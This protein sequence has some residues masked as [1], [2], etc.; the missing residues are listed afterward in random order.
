MTTSFVRRS[1]QLVTVAAA[2][3]TLAACEDKRVKA[4]DTGMTR[5]QALTQLAQEAKGSGPDSMPN[6]YTKSMYLIDGKQYEVLYFT[7]HNEKAKRDTV[8]WDDLTPIVLLDNR[9]IGKGWDFWDSAGKAMKIAV[10][11]HD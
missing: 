1:T 8:E 5:D 7:K 10:P 9:V 4:V 6:V 11:K 2:V 3:A